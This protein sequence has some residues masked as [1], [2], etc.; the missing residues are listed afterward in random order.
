MLRAFE[1]ACTRVSTRVGIKTGGAPR[2]GGDEHDRKAGSMPAMPPREPAD[3][4]FLRVMRRPADERRATCHAPGAQPCPGRSRMA[5]QDRPCEQGAGGP[6]CRGRT[7]MATTQDRDR[8]AVLAAC[9][10]RRRLRLTRLSPRPEPGRGPRPGM[11]RFSQPGYR[12]ARGSI[13]P[14]HGADW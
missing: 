3:K 7:V 12:A 4:P 9:R 11:G 14:H 2:R 10:P 6:G 8:R 1:M 13:V 5:R